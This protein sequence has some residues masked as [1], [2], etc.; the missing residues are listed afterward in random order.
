MATLVEEGSGRGDRGVGLEE[1][2]G[3]E[4]AL[5][6]AAVLL[7]DAVLLRAT[8]CSWER[9]EYARNETNGYAHARKFG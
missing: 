2:V 3:E 7:G 1:E 6:C 9:S 5:L 8:A 4:A